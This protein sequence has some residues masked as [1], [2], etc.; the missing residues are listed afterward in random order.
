MNK[1]V[2]I[3]LTEGCGRCALV[4]TPSCKNIIWSKE[5]YLLRN[6]ILA[7][8]L[9]E[10]AKWGQATYTFNKKNVIMIAGFKDYCAIMF[11]KGSLLKDSGNILIQQTENV[12]ATRQIR[13]KNINQVIDMEKIITSYIFEAIEIEKL[14]LKIEYKTTEQFTI[15]IELQNQ[16]EKFYEF[17]NAFYALTP[18]RQRAYIL[19]FSAPKQSKTREQRIKKYFIPIMEGKGFYD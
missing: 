4:G 15:P 8:N 1:D 7:C 18:G 17:K 13:F 16:F 19:H 2:E 14:G 3:I 6:I 9:N 10:E 12:Q 11:F 5:L